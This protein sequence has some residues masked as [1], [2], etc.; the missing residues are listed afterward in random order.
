MSGWLFGIA[1]LI[2]LLYLSQYAQSPFFAVPRLDALVNDQTARQMLSGDLPRAPFFRAP[3]Y[4]FFLSG[5]YALFGTG[6]WAPRLIQSAIGSASVVL[7]FG[8]GLRWFRPSAALIGAGA[9][10]LYGPLVY[11]TNELHT[12][13]LEVFLDLLALWLLPA[14]PWA[15]GLVLGVSATARPNI[16][17]VLPALLWWCA[18]RRGGRS[19]AALALCALLAPALVT[20]RNLRVSGDPVFVASQ[21]GV[22][23]FLGNRPESDG[24]T[25]STPVRYA[26]APGAP[27]EDSVSLYGRR[28][29]DEALGRPA[30]ASE[31]NRYWLGRVASFWRERPGDAWALTARKA[32]LVLGQPERRN[33][34]GYD[35]V[36]AEW[37]PLLWGL[38]VGFGAAAALGLTGMLWGG[39]GRSALVGFVGLYFAGIVAFF[40]ADRFRL[41]LVPVLLLF[42][43]HAVV[44]MVEARCGA[45]LRMAALSALL[46]ALLQVDWF[47]GVSAR[48][49]A[50]DEGSAGSRLVALGRPAEAEPR[51]RRAVASDPSNGDLWSGLGESLYAQG[52]FEDAAGAFAEAARREPGRAPF[53]YNAA[54]ALRALGREEAARAWL[55]EALRR[56]PGY[57]KAREALSSTG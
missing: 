14:S 57:A 36:R 48:D 38:P 21:G 56:D 12:P 1:L 39:R 26:P 29:A 24:V 37:A 34:T 22:N 40:A 50:G 31:A 23:L 9:M 46:L 32:L 44:R 33:N 11:H 2:H 51:L 45:R 43:G 10:A 17:I 19:A 6:P 54:L 47:P 13:V 55:A 30:S 8:V 35:Y 53:A 27:F 20:A 41:P 7:A 18:R 16:L 4:S 28:A 15:S 42:A 3:L 5:V 52:R 25:P 49:F